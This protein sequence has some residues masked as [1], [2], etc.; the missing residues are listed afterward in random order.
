MRSQSYGI[1]NF[2]SRPFAALATLIVEYTDYPLFIV[3][4]LSI[5]GFLSISKITEIEY[6]N[7]NVEDKQDGK[8]SMQ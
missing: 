7:T 1:S 8:Q 2:V 4:P 6:E 3:L 5:F